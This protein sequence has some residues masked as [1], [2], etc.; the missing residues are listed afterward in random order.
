MSFSSRTLCWGVCR[1]VFEKAKEYVHL[2]KT[3]QKSLILKNNP[4]GFISSLLIVLP[5]STCPHSFYLFC[6][7]PTRNTLIQYSFSGWTSPAGYLPELGINSCVW[8]NN[9][10]CW[11]EDGEGGVPGGNRTRTN[12][13]PTLHPNICPCTEI[14]HTYNSES[15][16]WGCLGFK[17][18]SML[19][20]LRDGRYSVREWQCTPTLTRRGWFSIMKECS[21]ESG[22]CHSLFCVLCGYH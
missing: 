13:W 9:S 5:P 11:G 10:S 6:I 16:V 19:R 7:F 21:P 2:Q 14:T 22:Y 20:F 1:E 17:P 4:E 12:H 15:R 3:T 18:Q 8:V